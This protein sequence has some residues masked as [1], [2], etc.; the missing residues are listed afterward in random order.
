MA[1]FGEASEPRRRSKHTQQGRL[2]GRERTR[3]WSSTHVTG[4]FEDEGDMS[5][6][7]SSSGVDEEEKLSNDVNTKP[8]F[9]QMASLCSAATSAPS[10]DDRPTLTSSMKTGTAS[11]A[12]EECWKKLSAELT[13]AGER[14]ERILRKH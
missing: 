3:F 11:T 5:G 2:S 4:F 8:S 9:R 1:Q 7:S 12:N 13:R 14:S 6:E 10:R